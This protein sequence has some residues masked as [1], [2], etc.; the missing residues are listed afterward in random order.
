MRRE[1]RLSRQAVLARLS[2]R[3]YAGTLTLTLTRALALTLTLTFKL[4]L[5]RT[6]T[7]TR[8]LTQARC[9]GAPGVCNAWVYCA[10]SDDPSERA[11]ADRCFSYTIHNHTRGECWLK[12]EANESHPI[13]HGPTLPLRMRR[14]PRADWPWAV[15]PN[16]WPWDVPEKVRPHRTRTRTRTL[17]PTR[18]CRRG[19]AHTDN[20]RHRPSALRERLARTPCASGGAEKATPHPHPHPRPRSVTDTLTLAL[21]LALTLVLTLALTL[22]LAVAQVTWQAGILA[23]R[24]APVWRGIRLPDWHHKFCNRHGPC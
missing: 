13:A 11:F 19:C 20:E 1:H 14:A 9:S 24:G 8:T 23:K 21:S 3:A 5:T 17:S 18:T 4:T 22:A 7:R 6:R 10:G 12:H 15:N 2:A 16:V